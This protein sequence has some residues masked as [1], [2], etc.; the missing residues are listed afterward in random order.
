MITRRGIFTLGSTGLLLPR[1][2]FAAGTGFERKFLFVFC[3]G[4]WDVV[5]VFAPVFNE[6]TD[7]FGEDV[8]GTVGG[9]QI[10]DSPTRPSVRSFFENWGDQTCLINGMQVPSVAHDVCTLLTMTGVTARG[11][12]D[13]V[14]VVAAQ[15]V[16]EY[17]V[18]NI[19]IAGPLF[20]VRFGSASVRVGAYGQLGELIKGESLVSSDQAIKIPPANVEALEEAF[21]RQRVNRWASNA[22]PGAATDF[23]AYE[24][25]ALDRA[26]KIG[27]HAEGLSVAGGGDFASLVD[28]ALYALTS[29]LS[30][31]AMVAYGA[32]GNGIWDTHANNDAQDALFEELFRVL[33]ETMN[34]LEATPGSGGGSLLDETTVVV[35]SEMGRTPQRSASGG[36]DHWTWTSAMLIGSGVQGGKTIG[37]WNDDLSGSAV[38]LAS[39]ETTSEGVV[40]GPGHLGATILALADIDPNEF[41]DPAVGTVLAA[42]ME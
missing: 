15:S 7:H 38:D 37:T 6:T 20:P 30:R 9:F 4:G 31:T 42:A 12:D 36:K 21:I 8:L 22:R 40:L 18:P 29:N 27:P 33:G 28:V 23:G 5:G 10:T 2:L 35:L 3:P 14:S 26:E 16:E 34:T 19:H 32:G 39:G 24:Q 17:L 1:R 41:V 11:L 13:W 25:I